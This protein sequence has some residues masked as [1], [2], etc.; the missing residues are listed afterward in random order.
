MTKKQFNSQEHSAQWNL[1]RCIGRRKN[2][3]RALFIISAAINVFAML[4]LIVRW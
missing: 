1:I 3:Y 4:L 2:L